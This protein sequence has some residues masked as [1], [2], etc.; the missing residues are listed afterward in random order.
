MRM[1]RETPK[2][3]IEVCHGEAEHAR[4]DRVPLRIVGIKEVLG[5]CLF[6]HLGELPF[7][8]D[9]ILDTDVESLSARRG[10]HVR[11]VWAGLTQPCSLSC[12]GFSQRP[13]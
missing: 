6:D 4:T 1:L 3:V 2:K 9:S 13:D 8:V 12:C 11:R 10:M 5:L 7:Q